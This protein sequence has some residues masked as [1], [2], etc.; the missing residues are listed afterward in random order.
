MI[1]LLI[2]TILSCVQLFAVI[3]LT[4]KYTRLKET[5]ENEYYTDYKNGKLVLRIFKPEFE[6]QSI[7]DLNP[8]SI[9]DRGV[10]SQFYMWALIDMKHE[11][12]NKKNGRNTKG[13]SWRSKFRG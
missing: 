5:K 1:Y 10:F 11:L 9:L 3:Y 13:H 6:F 4:V 8:Y 2:Q 7:G 12:N